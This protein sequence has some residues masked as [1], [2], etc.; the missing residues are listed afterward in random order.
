[1]GSEI[2]LTRSTH[3]RRRWRVDAKGIYLLEPLQSLFCRAA[4]RGSE[5]PGLTL[6]LALILFLAAALGGALNSVVGGATFVIFPALIFA[7]VPAI[8]A[9]A[10]SSV[11]VWPAA[12]AS[13]FAYRRDITPP[14]NVLAALATA[15]LA[16]GA[17]GAWLLVN[18]P[19]SAFVQLIPWLLL[20]ASLLFSFGGS[21]SARLGLR[22][23]GGRHSSAALLAI[24]AAQFVIAIYGGYFGA[25]M[26]ILMLAAFAVAD[27]GNIHTMNGVRS[28]LGLLINGVAIATFIVARAIEWRPAIVM[29]V[30]AT[31]AGYFG[32]ALAR[33]INPAVVR[34][35]VMAVAWGMTVYFFLRTY[36]GV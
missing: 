8:H 2:A 36:R 7:G 14:R 9:N 27:L 23:A 18:T 35:L 4:D 33:Q 20:F 11:V 6:T 22:K 10:T 30:G 29:V 34:R 19:G 31:L 21:V 3:R 28:L 12:L 32:A 5:R 24:G 17:I 1:V 26:G 13:A 16:G 15:S 25:G